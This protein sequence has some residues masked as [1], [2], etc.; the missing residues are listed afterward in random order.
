MR[1]GVKKNKKEVLSKW[2]KTNF[3]KTTYDIDAKGWLFDIS[4]CI[5]QLKRKEFSLDEIYNFEEHLKSKH[6][7]NNNVRAKI[8]QQLQILRDREILDFLGNGRYKLKN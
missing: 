8:R 3:I 6:P 1:N 4:L 7:L 5:D 2:S